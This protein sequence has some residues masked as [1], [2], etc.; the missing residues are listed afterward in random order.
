MKKTIKILSL[1]LVMFIFSSSVAFANPTSGDTG[2]ELRN[3][4][5]EGNLIYSA[6]DNDQ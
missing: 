6:E 4:V 2:T 1:L 3:P 5:S